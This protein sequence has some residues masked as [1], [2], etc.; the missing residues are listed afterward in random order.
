MMISGWAQPVQDQ[1]AKTILDQMSAKYRSMNSFKADFKQTLT[2]KAL[3][4]S[5]SFEGEIAVKGD[6]FMLKVPEQ[7]IYNNGTTVWTYITDANEVHEAF[8]EPSDDDL[9]PTNIYD[10]YKR[11]FKYR[12]ND[13]MSSGGMHVIDLEPDGNSDDY[14]RVRLYINANTYLLGKYELLD[15]ENNVYLY[16]VTNFQPNA[17]LSDG[18]FMFDKTKHPGVDVIDLK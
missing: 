16:D 6:M 9:T 2:N 1:K 11:G 13:E 12:Y 5:D 8:Y 4:I 7:E 17:N 15:N 10:I 18:Y 14:K 3:N